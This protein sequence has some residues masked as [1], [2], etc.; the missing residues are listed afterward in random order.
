MIT[1]ICIRDNIVK[2]SNNFKGVKEKRR[3]PGKDPQ[4]PIS[5][6]GKGD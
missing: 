5:R 1:N 3:T 4:L 6:G 2:I